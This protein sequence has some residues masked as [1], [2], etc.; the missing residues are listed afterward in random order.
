MPKATCSVIGC[1]NSQY[2]LIIWKQQYCSLHK[3]FYGAT[4]IC[5]CEPPFKLFPFPTSDM[6]EKTKWIKNINRIE[7]VNRTVKDKQFGQTVLV[8]H[9]KGEL[10]KPAYYHRVCSEH[11]VN[12]M[13]TESNPTPTLKLGHNKL[14]V[15]D[16]RELESKLPMMESCSNDVALCDPQAALGDH[17]YFR[18]GCT[19]CNDCLKRQ[20]ILNEQSE[21]GFLLEENLD[22]IR[23]EKELLKKKLQSKKHEE[24]YMDMINTCLCDDKQ[25]RFYTGL[26]NLGHFNFVQDLISNKI[27]L[28]PYWRRKKNIMKRTRQFC[29][30]LKKSGG[31]KGLPIKAELLITLMKIKLGLLTHDLAKRF[32]ISDSCISNIFKTYT[33]IL[34]ESLK[35]MIFWPDQETIRETLP[36]AF[37][38]P[39]PRTRT[40]IDC[41][42][43]FF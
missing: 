5:V 1:S 39:Y 15:R 43:I 34:A 18:T 8:K 20:K 33:K 24:K 35:F 41:S 21:K 38:K 11:F 22:S 29:T 30:T 7:S 6:E 36:K 28:T 31:Q 9:K 17:T 26:R 16:R 2:R 23:N 19:E 42:E 12:G 3:T 14:K 27:K 13:P 10:W 37:K 32:G 4:G 25:V 40:I